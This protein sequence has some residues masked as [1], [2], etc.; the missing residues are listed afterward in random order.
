VRLIPLPTNGVLPKP[1]GECSL[2][3]R[4]TRKSE[5]KRHNFFL[6]SVNAKAVQPQEEV[7]GLES[8]P[9][10]SVDEGIVL[11]NPESIGCSEI[12]EVS[13]GLIVEA[14]TRSIQSELQEPTIPESE[15][16]AVAP[17]LISMD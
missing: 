16:A 14:I 12:A 3:E 11:R 9:L 6:R 10:I 5:D 1:G 4:P 13:C 8:N 17:D 2:I 15:R 7:H